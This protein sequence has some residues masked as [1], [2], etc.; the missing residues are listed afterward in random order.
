MVCFYFGY[1][2]NLNLEDWKEV[3]KKYNLK[4]DTIKAIP[5][6]FFL[7]DYELEFHTFSS[8]R[9]GGVLDV[10]PKLGH[11]VVGKLFK[12]LDNFEALDTKECHPHFY[13]REE[14][15]ILDEK[16]NQHKAI[17]YRVCPEKVKEFVK[18]ATKYLNIVLKGYE[19][20]EISKKYPW[21]KRQLLLSA[22]QKIDSSGVQHVFVYGTL[23]KGQT[24]EKFIS[25]FSKKIQHNQ[26]IHGSLIDCGD[27]PGLIQSSKIVYGEIHHTPSISETLESLDRIE[28]F[29]GYDIESLFYRILIQSG[30]TTCWTYLFNG[31]NNLEPIIDSGNWPS[32]NTE[33]RLDLKIIKKLAKKRLKKTESKESG[34]VGNHENT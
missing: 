21:A 7:P 17:T 13:Q 34:K 2:S 30:I 29:L 15:T 23:C 9:K 25:K 8:S 11:V 32:Y 31:K 6:I 12:V 16:G 5:G 18:P 3:T 20:F 10:I 24:R 4:Q 1:G 26:K 19:D 28:G 22:K 14:V 33:K 27:Y